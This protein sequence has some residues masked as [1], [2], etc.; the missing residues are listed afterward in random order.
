MVDVTVIIPTLNEEDSIEICIKKIQSVFDK[1]NL[2]GEIIVSDSST[3]KTPEIAKKLGARVV[4]PDKKGYGYAYIYAFKY[5]RGKYIIMG[6]GDNTYDFLEIPKLLRP[7][8]RGEADFVIGTRLKGKIMPGAM[9]WLHRYIGNPLLTFILNLFF[10]IGVSDA[11]CGFRAITKEALSKLNLRTH[12]MEF[13]SEML[14]EAARKNLRVVEVPITYYPRKGSSKLHSFRDGWRH[15]KFMLIQAPDWL[16]ILPSI[17]SFTIGLITIT[18]GYL[19]LKTPVYIPGTY[20]MIAGSLL[21]ILAIQL[22]TLG[23][24]AKIYGEKIGYYKTGTIQWLKKYLTLERGILLGLL[25]FLLGVSHIIYLAIILIIKGYRGLPFK[26]EYM[27]GF[28]FVV[29]G[30]QIIFS[31]FIIS[32]MLEDFH[33]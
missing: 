15:L 19:K 12:G 14:I 9:P 32:M 16:Y 26:G 23:L 17:T 25:F 24:Y 8:Q 11:H 18:L 22:A 1:Y 13:A 33:D 4:F 30:V 28:T 31:S 21:I 27:F 7:L 10:K 29:I 20:S 6:D 5:A 2:N 3:D